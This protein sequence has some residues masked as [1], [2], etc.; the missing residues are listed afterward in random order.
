MTPQAPKPSPRLLRAADAERTE[1]DR[2]RQRLIEN[3]ESLRNELERLEAAL[4]DVDERNRLLDRLAP[5]PI[6]QQVD[7][8]P[9]RVHDLPRDG[10]R[11][12]AVRE[13]AVRRLLAH[14]QRPEALHYRDWY[15]LVVEDGDV[16]LGKDPLAVF[17]TQLSRSPVVRKGT[18]SGVYELDHDAPARLRVR[19]QNLQYQL[20]EL[21]QTTST[22]ADLAAIRERRVELSREIG[23]IEKALVEAERL[24]GSTIPGIAAI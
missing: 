2:H 8:V 6:C 10:L 9:A 19:L 7:Q 15:D 21:T 12:P 11:G 5:R 1:L 3:R 14:P 13:A 23:Q 4:R 20:R 22:T 24:L 17:L 16:V 18:Q